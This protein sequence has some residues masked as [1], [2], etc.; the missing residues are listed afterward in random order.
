M[1]IVR[2]DKVLQVRVNE[3]QL[4]QFEQSC[5]WLGVRPTERI[6]ALMNADF[7][8]HQQKLSNQAKSASVPSK[9][10]KAASVLT[11]AKKAPVAPPVQPMSL[12]ERIKADRQA[13]KLKKQ[14]REDKWL[15][16]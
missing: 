2:K 14:K 4:Q 12:S 9:D 7:L 3:A 10:V 5:A 16:G 13:K 6:R 11:I 8:L 15:Q 1:A